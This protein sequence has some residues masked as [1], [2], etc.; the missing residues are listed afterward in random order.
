MYKK[1][2]IFVLLSLLAFVGFGIFGRESANAQQVTEIKPPVA[3]P[4]PPI[5]EENEVVKVDTETVNVLFT[6]QDKSS[7]L[8]LN[9]KSQ[10]IRILENGQ[11]QEVTSFSRQVDLPLSLAI[12]IDTSISQQ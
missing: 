3:T 8:L 1:S 9:L 10:D 5:E 7:K 11:P 4:T 6:A 2:G 12:L